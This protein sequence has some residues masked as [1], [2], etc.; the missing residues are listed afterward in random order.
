MTLRDFLKVPDM[1]ATQE[2]IHQVAQDLGLDRDDA[3]RTA[4]YIAGEIERVGGSDAR[5]VFIVD[6]EDGGGGPYCSWCW[7]M[8]G[9]CAHIA[10]GKSEHTKKT[11]G[12]KPKP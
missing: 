1:M 9:L 10:G 5:L 6:D 4:D 11:E 3:V 7:R 12:D 2:Y 8:A